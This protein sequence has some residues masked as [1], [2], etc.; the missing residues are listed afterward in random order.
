MSQCLPPVGR[1]RILAAA[2]ITATGGVASVGGAQQL[3]GSIG[4]SLVILDP[5][6][7][8]QPR[9]AAVDLGRDGAARI[10]TTLA[11]AWPTPPLVLICVSRSTTRCTPESRPPALAA[12]SS[13]AA[14]MHWRVDLSRGRAA[15][16]A[17]PSAV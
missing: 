15:D 6:A 9:I 4:A 12:P 11:A 17:S 10:E 16:R 13:G 7:A 3:A 8:P 2:F 14:R 5:R 1:F